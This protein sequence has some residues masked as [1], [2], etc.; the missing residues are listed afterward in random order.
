MYGDEIESAMRCDPYT[1][2]SVVGVYA[3]DTLPSARDSG[4]D[5]RWGF[6][7]NTDV[8]S[9]PGSHWVSFWVNKDSLE[10]YD[11]YGQMP[12]YYGEHFDKYVRDARKTLIYNAYAVQSDY[13]EVCGLYAMF[14]LL[15]KSRNCSMKD[16]VNTFSDSQ[17]VNDSFILELMSTYFDCCIPPNGTLDPSIYENATKKYHCCRKRMVR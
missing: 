1:R 3:A 6:V 15:K 7:S 13:S 10:F 16:I 9:L 14:Y 8:M 11:S 5:R 12:G 2:R 17:D 4:Y